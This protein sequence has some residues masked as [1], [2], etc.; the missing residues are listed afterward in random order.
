MIIVGNSFK[1]WLI[2]NIIFKNKD[3]QIDK[4]EILK[5]N[6]ETL[7]VKTH[8][9]PAHKK[10]PNALKYLRERIDISIKEYEKVISE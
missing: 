9:V 6:I 5:A 10:T 7:I 3:I 2:Y 8:K 1:L 4:K